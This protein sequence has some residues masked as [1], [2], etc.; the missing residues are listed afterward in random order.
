MSQNMLLKPLEHLKSNLKESCNKM[1]NQQT[2]LLIYLG[3]LSILH[4]TG[5]RQSKSVGEQL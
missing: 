5:V 4:V 3:E 2:L 1:V